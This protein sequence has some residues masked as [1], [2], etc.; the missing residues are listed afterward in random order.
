MGQG[1]PSGPMLCLLG[2]LVSLMSNTKCLKIIHLEHG[3]AED[4][5]DHQHRTLSR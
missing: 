3:K 2:D 4:A 1:A 5:Q